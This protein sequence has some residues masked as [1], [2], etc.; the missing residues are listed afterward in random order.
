MRKKIVTAAAA[1]AVFALAACG[2]NPAPEAAAPAAP[3]AETAPAEA[4]PA[5]AAAP[6]GE[7]LKGEAE[8]F[9]GIVTAEL[10]MQDGTIA[11]VVLT[12]DGETP[13]VGGKALETLKAQVIA[14]GGPEIDGVSG[15][16]ITS[17]AVKNAVAKAMGIEAAEPEEAKAP[18][19]AAPAEIVPVEGGIQIGQVITAAHGNKCFSQVTAVVQGDTIIAAYIDEYQFGDATAVTGVPNGDDKENFGAGFAEGQTLFSKRVNADYYS[20]NMAEKAGSTVPLDKNY[21]EIQK[22]AVGKTIDE[23]SAYKGDAAAVDA[24]SGATLQDTGNYLAAIA[25][26]GKAAQKTQAVEYKGSSEDLTLKM[27]IGA[28][29]GNKCFSTAAVLTDGKNI[30]LSWIDEFQFGASSDVEAV[31]NSED[32]D[33][34]GAG[35]ADPS[36]V[37]FSKR[38]NADYYSNMM[39][40]K[41]GATV[42]IDE[43]YNAIQNHVNGMSIE[44]AQ[45]LSKDE[46]AVD[47]VSGA[48]L[49]DTAGYVGLIA[50][51][52]K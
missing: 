16:T 46:K 7:T 40:E 32:K 5:E 24:V 15:A 20:K 1:F 41:A 13:D 17:T 34:F 27:A 36:N 38:V 44:D 31:P 9:G 51:A 33:N 37:L 49:A 6:Q 14:A 50:E 8:G 22:F 23:L 2:T 39:N 26:A 12:G 28:A 42:R 3:A 45:A 48:T 52:A 25:E 19:M 35:Y 4:A 43:N 47:A 29:H 30:L 18:A 11:D 21:D 10:T